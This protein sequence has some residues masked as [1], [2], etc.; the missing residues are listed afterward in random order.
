MRAEPA[1]A[2]LVPAESG[3]LNRLRM[4][5]KVTEAHAR[6]SLFIFERVLQP[7]DGAPLHE[8]SEEDECTYVLSGEISCVVGRQSFLAA[9][10]A[11]VVKPRGVPHRCANLSAAPAHVIQTATPGRIEAFY[12]ELDELMRIAGDRSD[13]RGA[14]VDALSAR[15]GIRWV[16]G[17]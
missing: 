9:A 12:R 5:S 7:G 11:Y 16:A 15:Y 2:F 13:E 14:A 17:P 4:L 10:G 3:R 6:G 8:H 1:G